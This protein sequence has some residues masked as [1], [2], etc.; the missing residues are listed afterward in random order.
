VVPGALPKVDAEFGIALVVT[1]IP[2]HDDMLGIDALGTDDGV[3]TA[4][5]ELALALGSDD[6]AGTP[7]TG[8]IPLLP[9][10][11]APS[12]IVT[13][14]DV[15]PRFVAADDDDD[16][17]PETVDCVEP[18][19]LDVPAIPDVDVPVI[20]ANPPPSN[21]VLPVPPADPVVHVVVL[22]P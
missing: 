16:V 15:A 5:I 3:G 11:V 18:H 6:G 10:S 13:P 2:V 17:V 14:D 9:S 19:A 4:N 20:P 1:L 22:S 8:L 21:V 7:I 12:G